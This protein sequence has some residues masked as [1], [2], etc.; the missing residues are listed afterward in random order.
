L[1]ILL[2]LW[3]VLSVTAPSFATD[4]VALCRLSLAELGV[5]KKVLTDLKSPHDLIERYLSAGG[6]TVGERKFAQLQMQLALE[7]LAGHLRDTPDA[8]TLAELE[9]I[10]NSGDP[11]KA[12]LAAIC[13]IESHRGTPRSIE[14]AKAFLRGEQ[15]RLG[16]PALAAF[17]FELTRSLL[18]KR[19]LTKHE[20]TFLVS[21]VADPGS[22][23]TALSHLAWRLLDG[24]ELGPR[25]RA[26]VEQAMPEG[27]GSGR[28]FER[29]IVQASVRNPKRVDELRTEI[30]RLASGRAE[31]EP[32]EK[33]HHDGYVTTV[34]LMGGEAKVYLGNTD[35]LPGNRNDQAL[36][37]PAKVEN[38]FA[39]VMSRYGGFGG[40][41]FNGHSLTLY[42]DYSVSGVLLLPTQFGPYPVR[43]V[44]VSPAEAEARRTVWLK[45][46][47]SE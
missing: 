8:S 10:S 13:L 26:Y 43:R 18:K 39:L 35:N 33:A 31:V 23:G 42:W 12:G 38:D 20:A 45:P 22:S 19:R 32:A 29:E 25:L 5:P 2:P 6:T 21:L 24:Y 15:A 4:L 46:A 34:R 1:Q 11:S 30:E 41:E 28:D 17:E 14:L 37:T 27:T 47:H 16:A 44:L 40:T 3:V 36:V 9:S 7:E